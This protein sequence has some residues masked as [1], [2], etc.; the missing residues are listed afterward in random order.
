MQRGPLG[1]S[2]RRTSR[3]A[4]GLEDDRND[5]GLGRVAVAAKVLE[6]RG[7]TL[8][9]LS[10]HA[11]EGDGPDEQPFIEMFRDW[12]SV[13]IQYVDDAGMGHSTTS[14][15]PSNAVKHPGSHRVTTCTPRSGRSTANGG[16]RVL[17]DGC[18]GELG[19]AFRGQRC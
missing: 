5:T 7:D 16:V 18:G 6:E 14:M 19:A 13:D 2:R 17:F 3:E 8:A 12:A 11:G 10:S 9:A 1:R 15:A 4:R